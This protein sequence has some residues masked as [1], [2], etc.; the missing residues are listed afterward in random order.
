MTFQSTQADVSVVVTVAP[1]PGTTVDTSPALASERRITPSWT[2][3]QLKS[4]LETMTGI[5]PGN[6][7]LKLKSTGKGDQWVEGDHRLVGDWSLD[8]GCELEVRQL[9]DNTV[10]PRSLFGFIPNLSQSP[11][12]W[13]CVSVRHFSCPVDY[14]FCLHTLQSW[15]CWSYLEPAIGR[16]LICSP[17]YAHSGERD[18]K[19]AFI[20]LSLISLHFH[21][22]P[23]TLQQQGEVC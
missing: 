13:A 17:L 21:A 22:I 23:S 7:K 6:Q 3:S 19:I 15:R 14:I 20:H 11:E 8:K 1:T 9:I 4:K 5:P 18:L 12:P 10:F 2:V 16:F